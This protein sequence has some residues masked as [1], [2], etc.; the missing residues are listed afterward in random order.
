MANSRRTFLKHAVAVVATASCSPPPILGQRGGQSLASLVTSQSS[1][2]ASGANR[3]FFMQAKHRPEVIAHRGGEGQWP[4]ETMFAFKEAMNLKVDVLEMDVYLTRD[5]HLILMHDND[6]K[7]VTGHDGPGSDEVRK[8]TLAELKRLNAARKWPRYRDDP[9]PDLKVTSLEEVFRAFPGMRMN[10]EM[11]NAGR[12]YSPVRK[13]AEMISQA[14]ME[15]NVLVA[16]MSD[17]YI[18]EFRRLRPTVATSASR[19]ELLAFA[20]GNDSAVDRLGGPDALQ[21][22]DK[23]LFPLITKRFVDRAR[24]RNRPVHAW[25]VNDIEGM[26]RMVDLDVAGIIT[27]YPGPLLALLDRV[28]GG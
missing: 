9:N 3:P 6:I 25:T 20:A 10:I 14:N 15:A 5:G 27:D 8:F 28:S 26:R 11:K 23:L 24:R 18:R 21:M 4:G 16:S 7:S 17:D 19:S 1:S 13:L 12:D 2:N 22:K